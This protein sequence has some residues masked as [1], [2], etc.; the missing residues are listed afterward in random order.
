MGSKSTCYALGI[1]GGFFALFACGT[2]DNN[3][4]SRDQD[5]SAGG[6]SGSG[7][8]GGSGWYCTGKDGQ[9]CDLNSSC[10]Q[11]CELC[12]CEV[13]SME[14]FIIDYRCDDTGCTGGGG[15]GAG[16]AGG[17][18]GVDGSHVSEAGQPVASA[19][20][21]CGLDELCV[22]YYDG[23]CTPLGSRCNRVGGTTRDA[24]LVDHARCFSSPIGDEICG[25]SN[26][27]HFWGCGE[28]PCPN[29]PTLSDIN[30]YGP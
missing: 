8:A 21:T 6:S 12:A 24:I 3:V 30:C 17:S 23:R 9:R 10:W 4:G 25:L 5:G 28:P 19:C 11:G 1:L 13:L 18:P 29:Q 27:Q 2:S 26:G 14:P 16:G 20:S 15:G 7:G 22:A